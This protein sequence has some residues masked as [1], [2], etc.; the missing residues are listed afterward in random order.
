MSAPLQIGTPNHIRL[1]VIDVAR[2]RAFYT[3]VL[4]FDVALDGPPDDDPDGQVEDLL[5]GGVV[6]VNAG[7][8]VGLRPVDAAHADDRFD[9]FRVGL[10]HLSF[11]VPSRADLDTALA[12]YDERG[13]EHGPIREVPV[14]GMAFLAAFDPDGIAIELTAPL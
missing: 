8:M 4:G 7:V 6:L 5:Q 10:D 9:P 14:M 11:S 1:T 13:V 3:E 2:S 12:R